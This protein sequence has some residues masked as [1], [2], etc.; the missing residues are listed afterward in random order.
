RSRS[1]SAKQCVARM[2]ISRCTWIGDATDALGN[3]IGRAYYSAKIC[4]EIPAPCGL[5]HGLVIFRSEHNVIMQAQVCRRHIGLVSNA[6]V[7]ASVVL[8]L[9]TGGF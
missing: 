5:D 6:P 9:I 1:T 7:G 4:M 2:P 3:S 8:C